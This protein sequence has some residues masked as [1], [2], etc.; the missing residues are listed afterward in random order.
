MAL[1]LADSA[2]AAGGLGEVANPCTARAGLSALTPE[3]VL[4]LRLSCLWV[5]GEAEKRSHLFS[6][7]GDGEFTCFGLEPGLCT[8]DLMVQSP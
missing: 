6:V 7:S 5:V 4:F 2:A 8:V 1:G 3:R